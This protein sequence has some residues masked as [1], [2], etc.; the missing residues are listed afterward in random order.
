[1]LCYHH[2]NVFHSVSFTLMP[3]CLRKPPIIGVPS[4]SLQAFQMPHQLALIYKAP[5]M[6]EANF[7]CL[8]IL[9]TILSLIVKSYTVAKTDIPTKNQAIIS[10]WNCQA[11]IVATIQSSI[12]LAK[13]GIILHF[14]QQPYPPILLMPVLIVISYLT[15]H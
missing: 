5:S 9:V 12:T 8:R 11:F 15:I 2:L 14:N 10:R 3:A 4:L 13:K 1:M 7:S 6:A